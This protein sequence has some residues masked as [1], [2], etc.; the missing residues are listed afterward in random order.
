VDDLALALHS[1]TFSSSERRSTIHS[2][3]SFLPPSP[4]TMHGSKRGG[5]VTSVVDNST[6]PGSKR[7]LHLKGE[8]QFTHLSLSF[9]PHP[10]QCIDPNGMVL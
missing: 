4:A 2:P 6:T 9:H 3:F 7:C 10:Q 1:A 5:V 8:A